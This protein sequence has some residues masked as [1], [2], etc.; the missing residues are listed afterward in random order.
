MKAAYINQT[1][2]PDVIIFGDLPM[3]KPTRREC[4]IKV[5]AVDVNPI[6]LYVRSGAVPAKLTFPL[7]WGATSRAPWWKRARA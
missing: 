3:P 2:A 4:L 1:G 7:F 6:D 5:A